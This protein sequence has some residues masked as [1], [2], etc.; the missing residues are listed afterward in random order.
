MKTKTAPVAWAK[1]QTRSCPTGKCKH[2]HVK[3]SG[4]CTEIGCACHGKE[5]VWKTSK[6]VRS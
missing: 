2:S 6:K 5:V 4:P 3:D 1:G